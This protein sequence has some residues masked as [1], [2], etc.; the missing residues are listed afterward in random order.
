MGLQKVVVG[1]TEMNGQI[2]EEW[3]GFLVKKM[4]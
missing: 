1:R 3:A 2:R 4:T